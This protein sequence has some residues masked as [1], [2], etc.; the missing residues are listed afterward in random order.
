MCK[1]VQIHVHSEESKLDGL[2]KVED[3]VL[4]AK[5]L[6]YTAL[7]LTD[8]GVCGGIPDFIKSCETHGI[9]PLPGVE[10][11]T[12]KDRKFNSEENAAHREHIMMKYNIVD[13]KGKPKKKAFNDYMRLVKKKNAQFNLIEFETNQILADLMMKDYQPTLDFTNAFTVDIGQDIG[14]LES[15]FQQDVLNLLDH[16]NFHMVAIAMNNQGLKDLYKIVSD[17]H[18]NGFYSDPRT[19][20]TYIR[21]NGLGKHLI[22]TTA[23]LGSYFSQLIMAGRIDE[24]KAHIKECKETFAHFYLEKQ[25]TEIPEQLHVNSWIDQLSIETNTP[26]ILTTDVHYANKE[27]KDIHELL[28]TSAIGKC[29]GDEDRLIYAHEF[30]MKTDEE[31]MEKCFDE[32][33]WG[34]TLKI[35]E[36]V[37]VTLPKEPLLPKFKVEEG[38]SVDEILKKKAWSGLFE[39]ALK[40]NIDLDLYSKRLQTELNV[41]IPQGFADYF[42]VVSDYLSWGKD[43]GFLIGPGRGSAAGSLV[44]MCIK[45]TTV[46][47]I[48][49][50]LM[51]ERFLSP[52]RISFPDIDSDLSYEGCAAVQEHLKDVYGTDH[53]AQIGTKGTMA[54]RSVCKKVGKTMGY[55]I[56][57]QTKFASA[58]PAKPGIKLMEAHQES[59][60]VKALALRYPAWW[61]A[62]LAL[63]GHISSEG[64]HAGGVVLSPE[65]ITD[66]MPLRRDSDGLATTQ[67]DMEWVEKFLVKFDILKLETLDLVKDTLVYAGI[68]GFDVLE[69]I[70]LNDPKIYTDVYQ[71]QLLS[72]IFQVEGGGM[73]DVIEQLQPDNFEDI[74]AILA[75]YRPGPMD[76]IPSYIA[77]KKGLEP[78]VYDFPE[79]ADI[80]EGT[81]GVLVY[82]EQAMQM[83]I[84]LGGLSSGQSDWIRAG[85][86]KKK[87][88]LIDE[89]V[90]DMIYGNP[91]KDIVGAINKGHDEKKLLKLKEDW[92]KFGE[93]CFNR[94]H[95]VAYAIISLWT[96]WLKTYYPV[97]FMASLLTNSEGKKDKNGIPKNVAYQ[98]ETKDMGIHILPPDVFVSND[99]WTPVTYDASQ[100]IDGVT[101]IGEIRYGLAS[102]AGVTD[103]TVAELKAMN[104][105]LESA[106][107][108]MGWLTA[109]EVYKES[110]K[111]IKKTG[112]NKTKII[113]LIKAG[114]FDS[115]DKN[116]NALL[117]EFAIYRGD[118][119]DDIN[120]KMTK[121]DVM[122][123][124]KE[125][126]GTVISYE[127]KWDKIEDG[128]LTQITGVIES[129]DSWEAKSSGKTHYNVSL[130][131]NGE[132]VI[133]TIWGYLKEQNDEKLAVGNKV[134]LKGEKG[135]NKLTVKSITLKED[136]R[137][138][139]PA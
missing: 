82:Q 112:I 57:T 52:D 31:M 132:S 135:F 41:I 122:E 93:Y 74:V 59:E 81:Y 126:F 13:A 50:N 139:V 125:M 24:A 108:F 78:V 136:S 1:G 116:R 134:T 107:S 4:K 76:Y 63:E 98:K 58:I 90:G 47:P 16:G 110:V 70:D 115:L 10:L 124:E 73:K 18:L 114:A 32:E 127:S 118:P 92:T 8:H 72:G 83:S 14:D 23:C 88:K 133:C 129:I 30:W 71:K 109:F 64:V 89:W 21:E 67:F 75:L 38:D 29:L 26:K 9:K 87:I 27:D 15:Q 68:E 62:M 100:V 28:V 84:R 35:A 99:S 105:T 19:D 49:Y 121:L 12:T 119:A 102:I 54:A 94:S 53:V 113:N 103:D 137:E 97:E 34:N 40:E 20:L 51:F 44:A 45:I 65:P 11:Y 69:D 36:M 2:S 55:D 6:G 39:Y 46:D 56:P 138:L 79:C 80:L 95:S 5:S 48:K 96:A 61:E 131:M 111:T 22:A 66:R 128:K 130:N 77:R 120:P 86:A 33:A 123:Y 43:N 117:I 37:N 104:I 91:E 25:A 60:E 17:A 106:G 3:L 42:L 7:G 101:G 85:I